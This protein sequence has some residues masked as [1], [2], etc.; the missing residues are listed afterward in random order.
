ML[1]MAPVTA[2]DCD[3]DD[4]QV[5][6]ECDDGDVAHLI[7]CASV[8]NAKPNAIHRTPL[9]LGWS[10]TPPKKQTKAIT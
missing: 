3:H 9:T 5:S 8:T 10:I 6:D 1:Y 7:T 4:R 2:E